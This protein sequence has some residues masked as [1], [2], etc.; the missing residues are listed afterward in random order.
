[1]SSGLTNDQMRTARPRRAAGVEV[2]GLRVT[3]KLQSKTW[4]RR[5]LRLPDT[6][7]RTFELDERG[8]RVFDACDGET[9][10]DQIIGRLSEELNVER[11]AFEAATLKFLEMMLRRG[12]I[13]VEA[14]SER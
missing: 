1:M 2:S 14:G 3:V 11:G 8:K 5:V 7:T 13:V 9:S 4:A 6:T 10:I 12:M